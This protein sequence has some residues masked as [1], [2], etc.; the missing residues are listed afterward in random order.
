MGLGSLNGMMDGMVPLHIYRKITYCLSF[1]TI[2]TTLLQETRRED[3]AAMP[4]ERSGDGTAGQ[5][6]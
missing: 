2:H 6:G 3:A 5:R 1:K 4:L